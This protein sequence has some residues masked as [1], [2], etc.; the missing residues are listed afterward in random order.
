MIFL[1]A[2]LL[3]M[4]LLGLPVAFA[5]GASSLAFILWGT[6][7]RLVVLPQRMAAGSDSFILLAVPFFLLAGEIMNAAGLTTRLVRFA[8]AV[9][10]GIKGGLSYVVVVVNMVMAGVS[11]AAIADAA[12][13]GSV[14]IPAMVRNGYPRGF[15]AAVNAAAATIGPVIPPSIGF[16]IYASLAQVSVAKLFIA[17]AIPGLIMGMY[18]IA[19]CYIVSRR[20]KLPKGKQIQWTELAASFKQAV[21]ALLMPLI[22]LGGIVGG[23]VTPTEAGMI[24]VV[25]GVVLGLLY[26]EFSI[27][28]IPFM[29]A[30]A[31]KQSAVLMFVIAC[32]SVFGWLLTREGAPRKLVTVFGGTSDQSWVFMVVILGAIIVL[33]CFMEGASI[34]II[35][36][37]LLL[38]ILA[39]LEI[40]LI[41]FGVVFQ[42]AIMI[43]L[44]TPPLGMLLFVIQG[45]SN[46][47]IHEIL[48]ELWPFVVALGLVLLLVAFVPAITLWLPARFG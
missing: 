1:T 8:Q 5:I 2:L 39:S 18:M 21:W 23:I 42:L 29:L 4:L 40:D 3:V 44:L 6:D 14:M 9:V 36:T 46:V 20:R 15:A 38:P 17:G 13:V 45:V 11:G 27:R 26:Q 22:I 10:G 30:K 43:G 48:Q 35:L 25:Y 34:M 37:P 47:P 19:V 7:L 31:A 32:S 24:A 33:G 28:E 41:H 16:V 12:A